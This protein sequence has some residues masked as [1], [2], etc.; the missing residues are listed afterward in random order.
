M[1]FKRTTAFFLVILLQVSLPALAAQEEIERSVWVNEAIAA[2]YTY[3]YKNFLQRQKEIAKF[4]TADGWIAYSKALNDSKLPEAVQKNNYFVSAV[5]QLP[6][7]IKPVNGA[8]WQA[9]MPLLVVYKNPQY[10]QKQTL[11]V[12]IQ[13]KEVSGG[14]GVRGLAITSLQSKVI[15]PPCTCQPNDSNQHKNTNS[16]GKTKAP[17]TPN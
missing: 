4:F 3:N 12:T 11:S 17:A 15:E 14:Q 1:A 8:I 16:N 13:F 7:E 5:A 6:P 10:Q 9:N 2:T